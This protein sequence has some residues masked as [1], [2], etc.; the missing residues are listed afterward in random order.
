MLALRA[1]VRKLLSEYH[2]NNFVAL[3]FWMKGKLIAIEGTDASGKQL[4]TNIGYLKKKL[5]SLYH[6]HGPE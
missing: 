5:S 6:Y 4:V 1:R 3:V 2:L